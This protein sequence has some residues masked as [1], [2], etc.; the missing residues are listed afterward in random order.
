MSGRI[1]LARVQFLLTLFGL[2]VRVII[3]LPASSGEDHAS[4]L[5]TLARRLVRPCLGH[6]FRYRGI[7]MGIRLNWL[8]LSEVVRAFVELYFSWLQYVVLL[9]LQLE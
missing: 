6:Q 8:L 5:L 4:K 3:Q 7:G 9:F 1:Q 2:A